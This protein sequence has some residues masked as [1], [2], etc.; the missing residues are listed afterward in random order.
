MRF[1]VPMTETGRLADA[2]SAVIRRHAA[3][4][5]PPSSGGV[6]AD[7]RY[8]RLLAEIASGMEAPPHVRI[9]G[10]S[11]AGRAR[12]ASALEAALD[13]C[14]EVVDANAPL[15]GSAPD[16]EVFAWCTAPCRHE[17]Q[18]LRRPR[19]HPA[20]VVATRADTWAGEGRPAWADGL[21][22]VGECVP[23]K[24]G[25][26]R[27]CSLIEQAAAEVPTLRLAVATLRLERDCDSLGVRD[28]AEALCAELSALAHTSPSP[29]QV[30]S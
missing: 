20:V 17:L 5:G 26:D 15:P 27:V 2:A 29:E 24:P 3:A 23:G 25:F 16:I 13:V 18:W 28:V 1:D 10:G 9:I 12:L 11:G 14:C 19:R 4:L 22:A 7:A 8:G 6:S 30:A 21:V